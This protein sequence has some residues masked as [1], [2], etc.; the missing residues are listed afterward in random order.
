MLSP[1]ALLLRHCLPLLPAL[2][3]SSALRMNLI[4]CTQ[5]AA[6][7]FGFTKFVL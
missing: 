6:G 2:Q 4:I 7:Q 5:E 3:S 1:S